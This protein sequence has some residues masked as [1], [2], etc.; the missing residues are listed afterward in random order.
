VFRRLGAAYGLFVLL[1]LVPPI[2]AGGALS[3]GRI[4]STL[5]PVFIA[6]AARLPPQSVPGWVAAFAMLQGLVATLFFTWRELF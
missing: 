2:F 4:S 6:L 1:N 3:M 5:F